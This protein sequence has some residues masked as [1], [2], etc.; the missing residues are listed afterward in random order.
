MKEINE[1]EDERK[2]KTINYNVSTYRE[3]NE[4]LDKSYDRIKIPQNNLGYHEIEY[5]KFV[6]F[7]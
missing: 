3:K 6:S 7:L 1:K 4:K 2:N 5:I